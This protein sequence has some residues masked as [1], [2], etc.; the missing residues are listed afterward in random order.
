MS[1]GIHRLWK[2]ALVEAIDPR[3]G[4]RLL[5]LAGGTGDIARR[6]HARW[7][8]RGLEAVVCDINPRML[9]QGRER[10]WNQGVVK[11]LEW[12]CGDAEALPLRASSFDAC[13]IGFGIRNVT[14]IAGALAEIARAL[15][16]G[17]RFLC[18]EFSPAVLPAL[19]PAYDAFS[20]NVIPALGEMVTGDRAAYRYLV[21]S[22]RRFPDPARFATMIEAAGFAGVGKRLFSGGIAALHSAFRV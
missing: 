10:A 5:D 15:K 19:R 17:G 6:A 1:A 9:E 16:P 13:T 12:L 8:A 2:R 3:P 11:G 14:S 22:I 7:Q 20:F 21:E 4:A 18:L